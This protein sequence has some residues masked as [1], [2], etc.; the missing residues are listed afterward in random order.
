MA[1]AAPWIP[2]S[3]DRSMDIYFREI[4]RTDLLSREEELALARRVRRGD[5]AAHDHL[6]QANLRFVVSV[7]RTYVGRGLPLAD[8]VN[9]GNVGLL[10]AAERFDETRGHRFISYAVWWIRQTILQALSEQP[11]VVRV[12]LNR[13]GRASRMERT[14]RELGQKLG[15]EPSED[16]VARALRVPVQE[17]TSHRLWTLQAVSLDSPSGDD[18]GG[19]LIEVLPD[20]E[21]VPADES[22]AR[23]DMEQD[24]E[25][26]LG[27]LDS[28]ERKILIDYF[29]LQN[30]EGRTLEAIGKELRLTRERVRQL[31]DRAMAKIRN[32]PVA[33]RLKSQLT[34]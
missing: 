12:P 10:K 7:A 25:T 5:R 23:A 1:S 16:E 22:L 19:T 30:G 21:A 3:E 15:R 14:T 6:I 17:V 26:A 2:E 32:S 31:K 29:G 4:R 13:T 20:L 28:R 11:R 18:H 24:L 27:V 8:L 33:H 34:P 9:E